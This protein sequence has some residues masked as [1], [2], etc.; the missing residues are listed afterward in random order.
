MDK[1]EIN[2]PTA[3]E[4]E[5]L[6][7]EQQSAMQD[8]QANGELNTS[9]TPATDRPEWLD[10]K[11]KSPEDMAKAYKELSSKI[12]TNETETNEPQKTSDDSPQ[13]NAITSASDEYA[14]KGELTED[15]YGELAKV[16]ITKDMVD[17]YIAGQESSNTAETTA[18]QDAIGGEDSY[19][20]MVT[21]A[22]ENLS[23]AEQNAYDEVVESGS[24]EAAKLAVQGLNARFQASGKAPT[25]MQGQSQG[26]G[27]VPFNSVAQ[28]R[29]AMSD[30]RYGQDPAFRKQVEQR[31][32]ISNVL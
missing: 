11:F 31:I 14:E 10:E 23:E 27:V 28:V 18:I 3:G 30:K 26:S 16:G 6:T 29:E 7:L 13:Q 15:T 4:G 20:A 17:M 19:K 2:E 5:N 12:G 8:A 25:L 22:S 21:W 32:A 9:E 1:V 24:V